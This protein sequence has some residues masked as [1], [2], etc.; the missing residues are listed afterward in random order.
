MRRNKRNKLLALGVAAAAL[1]GGGAFTAT[2]GT[3]GGN[4]D[5]SD[6]GVVAYGGLDIQGTTNVTSL[7]YGLDSTNSI[8]D[9]VTFVTDANTSGE[10][11][12]VSFN[13]T[14]TDTSSC[15]TSDDSTP[16]T[17]TCDT[18][19]NE[20]STGEAITDI[21]QTDITITPSANS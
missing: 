21:T 18:E 1:A 15:S 17:W 6:N 7:T 10:Q 8:V 12:V 3:V 13:G 9:S 5:A 4:V 20:D 16:V 11:A 14:G 2:L 19:N